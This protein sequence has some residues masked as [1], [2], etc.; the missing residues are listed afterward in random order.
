MP[1]R[2]T[3]VPR[4]GAPDRSREGEHADRADAATK[5]TEDGG[6][7]L[8]QLNVHGTSGVLKTY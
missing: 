5:S 4:R 6:D 2:G 8:E 7:E 3:P 1:R